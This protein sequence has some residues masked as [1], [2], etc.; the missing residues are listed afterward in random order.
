MTRSCCGI[1]ESLNEEEESLRKPCQFQ[2]MDVPLENPFQTAKAR[3]LLARCWA[4]SQQLSRVVFSLFWKVKGEHATKRTF[5]LQHSSIMLGNLLDEASNGRAM[6]RASGRAWCCDGSCT[7]FKLSDT[8]TAIQED[9]WV[10]CWVWQ[11]KIWVGSFRRQ[12]CI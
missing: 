1:L 5:R 4:S 7:I 12:S 9:R 10:C 2:K 3:V 8:N 11:S 6:F